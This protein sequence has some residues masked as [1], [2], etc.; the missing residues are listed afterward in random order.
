MKYYHYPVT[1]EQVSEWCS[2]D[3]RSVFAAPFRW[4]D[5]WGVANGWMAL[6]VRSFLDCDRECPE[7]VE[8]IGRL[9]WDVLVNAMVPPGGEKWG[10]LDERRGGLWR[11]GEV[12]VWQRAMVHGKSRWVPWTLKRVTVGPYRR[13]VTQGMLQLVSKLPRAEVWLGDGPDGWLMF[14]FNGGYGLAKTFK[15]ARPGGL[16]IWQPQDKLNL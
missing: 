1:V 13:Q 6:R 10:N 7:A 16:W 14:R 15:E 8:R 12:R 3:E 4:G 9:P 5:D 11:G 2:P